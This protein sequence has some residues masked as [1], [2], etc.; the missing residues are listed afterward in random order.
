[1][2][3]VVDTAL[4]SLVTAVLLSVA[5]QK[6][7]RDSVWEKLIVQAVVTPLPT[8]IPPSVSVEPAMIVGPVPQVPAV[9]AGP[10]TR[11]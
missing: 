4:T 10:P 1:M 6:G 5:V 2:N 3:D 9:G 7:A 8:L 11:R